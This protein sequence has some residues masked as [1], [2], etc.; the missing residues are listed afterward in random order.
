MNTSP[1]L[2]SV[3]GTVFNE[4]ENIVPFYERLTMAAEKLDCE[5]EILFVDD[6][7]QDDSSA[8]ILELAEKDSRIRA[9]RLS[10]NF[11][12]FNAAIAGLDHAEGDAIMVTAVDLQEPP[13]LVID[14]VENWKKGADIV[15]AVRT[16]RKDS[17]FKKLFPRIFYWLLRRLAF[18]DFPEQG[19]DCGLFDRRV[20]NAYR[21]LQE[22]TGTPFYTI[23]S[24]GFQSAWVP[25]VRQERVAHKS[26]WTFWRR[27]A[28]AIDTVTTYSYKPIRLIS[29]LGILV[30]FLSL[31]YGLTIILQWIFLGFDMPG[32]PSLVILILFLGGVQI[33]V[34]GVIAEYIFI[35]NKNT[36]KSPRYIVMDV[37]G[38]P[39]MS[40]AQ[41]LPKSGFVALKEE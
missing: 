2:V 7:S 14:F 4:S 10:R 30:S 31:T 9:L 13:E 37:I 39:N 22:R 20:I 3:V 11:G 35:N 12:G 17:F 34:L 24:L 26:G 16:A 29:L 19:M 36:V 15:W 25:Y 40:L 28:N 18:P 33:S 38:K 32:W 27:M 8:K 23:Y 1:D 41:D 21:N 6:G 5:I